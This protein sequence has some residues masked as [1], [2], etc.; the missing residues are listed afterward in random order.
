[1]EIYEDV[2]MFIWKY[3]ETGW[4]FGL[5]L[6]SIQLGIIIPTDELIFFRGVGIPP[7]TKYTGN[8]SEYMEINV[9]F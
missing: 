4:W 2:E 1:M 6:F 7:T 8:I 9:F 3:T 5:F